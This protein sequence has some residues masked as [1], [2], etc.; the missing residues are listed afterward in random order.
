MKGL[1]QQ[2]EQSIG[3][4]SR[5]S[6]AIFLCAPMCA[7]ISTVAAADQ[8]DERFD[9]HARYARE[10]FST[11]CFDCHSNDSAEANLNIESLLDEQPLVRNQQFPARCL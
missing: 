7:P 8:L 1:V 4:W 6:A 10:L 3:S 2:I 9:R 11:Y 5:V